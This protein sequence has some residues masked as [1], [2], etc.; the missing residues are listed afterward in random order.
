MPWVSRVVD[1][2]GRLW[3]SPIKS[4]PDSESVTLLGVDRPVTSPEKKHIL[5]ESFGASLV[6]CESHVFANSASASGL[7]W[8]VVRGVCDGPKTRL[9][10]D[11]DR[12]VD[13]NG[14]TRAGFA[15]MRVLSEPGIAFTVML[16][17]WRSHRAMRQVKRRVLDLLAR[18]SE[19]QSA[20]DRADQ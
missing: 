9:P 10:D 11:I 3:D 19:S 5:A 8:A 6:D 20:T 17:A 16:L 12:W 1:Q 4:G 13:E 7:R 18:E 14:R 2:D 15:V